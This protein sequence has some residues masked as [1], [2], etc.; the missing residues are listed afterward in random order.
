MDVIYA[1]KPFA[2]ILVTVGHPFLR[3]DLR[4]SCPLI[5]LRR[6]TAAVRGHKLT[7]ASRSDRL[8]RGLQDHGRGVTQLVS[9]PRYLQRFV[10]SHHTP[11]DPGQALM[12]LSERRSPT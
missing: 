6:R 2:T 8:M 3:V 11:T 10:T 9:I 5:P 4:A 7:P 1:G 12:S